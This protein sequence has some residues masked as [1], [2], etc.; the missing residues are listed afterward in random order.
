MVCSMASAMLA[1]KLW[2]SCSTRNI[3]LERKKENS[4]TFT[5]QR[6]IS[7]IHYFGPVP[8]AGAD[9]SLPVHNN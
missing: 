4:A 5:S 2:I 8:S 9:L 3:I 6:S 1:Y 7:D